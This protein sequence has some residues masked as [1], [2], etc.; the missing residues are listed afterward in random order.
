MHYISILI[1]V[2]MKAVPAPPVMLYAYYSLVIFAM[3]RVAMLNDMPRKFYAW[4]VFKNFCQK[5]GQ[6]CIEMVRVALSPKG[7]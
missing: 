2:F 6:F 1:T 3:L 7:C 4:G 5:F